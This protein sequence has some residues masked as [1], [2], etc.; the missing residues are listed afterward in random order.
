MKTFHMV[1]AHGSEPEALRTTMIG[2]GCAVAGRQVDDELGDYQ[3]LAA[4]ELLVAGSSWL[5]QS[6]TCSA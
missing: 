2:A 4:T 3:E 6:R 1:D 5:W